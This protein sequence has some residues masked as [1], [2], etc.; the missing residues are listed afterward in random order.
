M[1]VQELI[2][3]LKKLPKDA[4]VYLCKDLDQVEE[5]ILTDLYKLDEVCD[6]T[7]ICDMGMDF[8]EET[9]VILSFEAER[10]SW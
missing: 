10:V 1:T 3:Q 8:E 5:G 4:E 6:Q 2:K 9:D 7:R